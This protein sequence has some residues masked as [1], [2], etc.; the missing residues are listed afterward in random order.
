MVVETRSHAAIAP[1]RMVVLDP[2]QAAD[3]VVF[4]LNP[5]VGSLRGLRLGLVDNGKHKSKEV[6]HA[7]AELLRPTYGFASV[8]E[9]RKTSPARAPSPEQIA[10]IRQTCDVVIA[11]IGD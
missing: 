3:P 4:V 10:E 9:W 11:G 5:R 2:T 8:R 7:I 6:L 1:F